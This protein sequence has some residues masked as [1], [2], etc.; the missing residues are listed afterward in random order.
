MTRCR[1]M[2]N[3]DMVGANPSKSGSVLNL[4]RTPYSLPS[5]LNNVVHYWLKEEGER[6]RSRS[7]GGTIAPLPWNYSNY[8]AGSD[9]FMFT[10][11]TLGIPGVMLNQNPDRFYHTSTDTPDKIDPA[12]MAYATRVITLSALTLAHPKHASKEAI[13]AH[14][15]NET[16]SLLQK[17]SS[18]ALNIFGRCLD[19]PEEVY[20][21]TMRWLGY[22]QKLGLETIDTAG[23]EWPLISEQKSIAQALKASIE[24]AYATEMVVMR[25]GYVGACAEAGLQA[26][27][28]E[29]FDLE[30]T[31]FGLE[32]RRTLQYALPPSIVMKLPEERWMT[33]LKLREDDPHIIDRFDELLNLSTEWTPLDEI[34]EKIC[35]QFGPI[36]RKVFSEIIDDLKTLG[37][38]EA[39]EV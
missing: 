8:S 39:K 38:L 28:D 27:D 36:E 13:L 30:T 29:Q 34:W 10:D 22:I 4:Y 19:N 1:M 26:K 18:E 16:V 35:L 3:A 7:S 33:Y 17:V 31:D 21:R 32:I 2:I 14:C 24:M 25:K 15:R 20:P 6:A 11:S 37:V 12:Q 23:K 9:H 5:S